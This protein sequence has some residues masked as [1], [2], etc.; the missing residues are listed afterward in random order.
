MQLSDRTKMFVE[1]VC[2]LVLQN[3]EGA[4]IHS[5]I[6]SFPTIYIVYH[7]VCLVRVHLFLSIVNGYAAVQ[8]IDKPLRYI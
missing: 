5:K 8:K 1:N 6:R 7:A 4:F 2:S 3:A